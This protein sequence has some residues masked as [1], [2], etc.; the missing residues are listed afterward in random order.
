MNSRQRFEAAWRSKGREQ[1]ES[2]EE[3]A[4]LFWQ[5]AK[6]DD[7]ARIDKLEQINADLK[8][9]LKVRKSSLHKPLGG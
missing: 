1:Y 8:I 3:C 2:F 5:A 9:G 4:W 7:R 6:R